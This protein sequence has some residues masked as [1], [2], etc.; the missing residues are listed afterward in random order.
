M[1]R[2]FL[3][4]RYDSAGVVGVG[5]TVAVAIYGF[6]GTPSQTELAH[7]MFVYALLALG[8]Y[9]PLIIT[10]QVS[11]AYGAYAGIGAYSVGILSARYSVDAVLGFA[12]GAL[13]AAFVA[14]VLALATRRLSGY[15][16]A[17]GTLLAAVVFERFLLQ[18]KSLTGGPI[19]LGFEPR[20]FGWAP[21]L[22]DRVLVAALLV[23]VVGTLVS[24]LARSNLGNSLKLMSSSDAGAQSVGVDTGLARVVA[25]ALGAALSSIAGGL[26]AIN[27]GF[28][29]PG[30]FSL[31]IA[32][33]ILF[34][35]FLGGKNSAWGN[36]VGAALVAFLLEGLHGFEANRLLF[37][38][39]VILVLLFA[40]SGVLGLVQSAIRRGLALIRGSEVVGESGSDSGRSAEGLASDAAESPRRI[41]PEADSPV[42]LE[43]GAVCKRFGGLTVLDDVSLQVRAGEILGLVGPNG[44]GKTTLLNIVSGF[45]LHD[46]G[47]LELEGS[48][49]PRGAASRARLGL[50]RT[51]QHPLLES[52]L[53]VEQN[54]TLGR[55][56]FMAPSSWIGMI[57]WYVR[58][59]V[60]SP[61]ANRQTSAQPLLGALT[62][63]ADRP[64]SE[65]SFGIE[66]LAE[67]AR[68][69]SGEPRVLLMDEPFAGLDRV[70][71]NAA[72]DQVEG[73]VDQTRAVVVVDHNIDLMR[74][75]CD[76]IVVLASGQ[77]I[78][79]GDP[80]SV[81]KER[82]TQI[83]YFGASSEDD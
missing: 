7:L 70:S 50:G 56:R 58:S 20:L 5:V 32:F 29:L 49:L 62:V 19:G 65:T 3:S 51:F 61:D 66:K 8:A 6:T 78:A 64:V 34:I 74:Q 37:A 72:I 38:V 57:R 23:I 31:E 18:A 77:V 75:M 60:V 11:L 53:T 28:L 36:V 44:A 81:M 80:D 39:T 4:N 15:F 24:R 82:A 21:E 69:L 42:L 55:G 71:I 17:I 9:I 67:V 59:L 10:G 47:T 35:P 73:W 43:V 79:N 45:E 63:N 1:R 27:Q 22:R 33:L 25:L 12:I 14:T 48:T 2:W 30:S 83:A 52:S 41:R 40:P 46:S 76:R 26:I 68:A 16:L 54:V 13:L